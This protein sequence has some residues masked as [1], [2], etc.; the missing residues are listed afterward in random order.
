MR[1]CGVCGTFYPED[2]VEL[3]AAVEAMLGTEK[4]VAPSGTPRG[5]IAPH[6]GYMYSGP[7]AGAA[8]ALLA[9]RTYETVVVV[10]P[11]HR[12]AFADVSV[13][14]GAGYE[15]PLG[16]VPIDGEMREL[17]IAGDSVVGASPRGHRAEHAIEVQL[18]FLQVVLGAF[19]LVPLVIGTPAR[20]TCR[21]LGELLGRACRGRQVLLVASTD[22]SHYFPAEEAEV[23]DSVALDDIGRFD[24]DRLMD[25][26][27]GGRTEACGGGPAF[28]VMKGLLLLGAT[29]MQVVRHCTSGDVT[30][31]RRSVVG[32]CSAVAWDE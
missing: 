23:L 20:D 16:P 28:A 19:S 30:G 32:Y 5:V 26:L 3:R 8:Y 7:T 25:D 12:E 29:R 6:A 9:G 1:P 11:S 21:A 18:P 24:P 13:F 15:T 22:L 4:A 14:P 31:D 2:P 10:A 17:L 27:E